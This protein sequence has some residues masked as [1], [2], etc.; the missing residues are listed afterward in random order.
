MGQKFYKYQGTGNDFIMIDNREQYFSGKSDVSLISRL[1]DRRFG[2]GA[3]GLIVLELS[4]GYDFRMIYYNSNGHE[5]SMCGNGLNGDYLC[6]NTNSFPTLSIKNPINTRTRILDT[7]KS[8][9]IGA[10]DC[11]S[12]DNTFGIHSDVNEA[13]LKEVS[14]IQLFA[15]VTVRL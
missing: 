1:C 2:V 9:W 5:G 3:D 6:S 15:S 4:E 12:S 14:L 10:T 8:R 13:I 11:Q 7:I